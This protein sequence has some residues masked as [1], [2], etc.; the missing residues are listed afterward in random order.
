MPR[1]FLPAS[2]K[3]NHP[4]LLKSTPN[5]YSIS[6]ILLPCLPSLGWSH[7]VPLITPSFTH[8]AHKKVA[9]PI[10]HIFSPLC[11][12]ALKQRRSGPNFEQAPNQHLFFTAWLN[13]QCQHNAAP[14]NTNWRRE[15]TCVRSGRARYIISSG[16]GSSK[17]LH[18]LLSDNLMRATRP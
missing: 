17:L 4:F 13:L 12:V 18:S 7:N 2:K 15:P 10:S 5:E 3:E 16:G 9:E 14:A 1:I 8:F 11:K 6:Y